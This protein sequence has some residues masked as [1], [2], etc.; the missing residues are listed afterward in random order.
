MGSAAMSA[1]IPASAGAFNGLGSS[2]MTLPG[3]GFNPDLLLPPPMPVGTSSTYYD[4]S[5]RA[6]SSNGQVAA[7]YSAG[8]GVS[9]W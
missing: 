7:S 8:A 9:V 2:R 3:A 1:G 5:G 4:V 6:I